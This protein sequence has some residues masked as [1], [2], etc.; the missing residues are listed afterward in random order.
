[1][2]VIEIEGENELVSKMRLFQIE[3]EKGKHVVDDDVFPGPLMIDDETC[4]CIG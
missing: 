2:G 3:A 1:M 4:C